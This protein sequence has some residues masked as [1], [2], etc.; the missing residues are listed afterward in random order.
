V[1]AQHAM[2]LYKVLGLACSRGNALLFLLQGAL[3]CLRA[4][5]LM[6]ILFLWCRNRT[7]VEPRMDL[8]SLQWLGALTAQCKA[9]H[10]TAN[11]SR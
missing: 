4:T 2:P 9:A 8:D 7:A 10:I 3:R 6:L 11:V 5:H 1:E